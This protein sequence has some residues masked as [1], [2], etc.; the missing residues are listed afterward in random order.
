MNLIDLF[1]LVAL[2]TDNQKLKSEVFL[3]FEIEDL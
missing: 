1:L 2:D 3:V